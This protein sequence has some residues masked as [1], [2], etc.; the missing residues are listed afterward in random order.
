MG[1]IGSSTGLYG[2]ISDFDDDF[3]L[4]DPN[5]GL[6]VDSVNFPVQCAD[7][8]EFSLDFESCDE[9]ITVLSSTVIT[10]TGTIADA[11][12]SD[13]VLEAIID[14]SYVGPV[15]LRF[16]VE[17]GRGFSDSIFYNF[18]FV[19]SEFDPI[20][21]DTSLFVWDRQ[22]HC[23]WLTHHSPLLT[24]GAEQEPTKARWSMPTDG[25]RFA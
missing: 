16:V 15:R 25:Q 24:N 19:G 18:D 5:T 17:D 10:G 7:T 14:P 11:N 4:L 22:E 9:D 21:E 13:T 12:T 3:A 2:Y 6:S 1:G 23:K 8:I 20:Q